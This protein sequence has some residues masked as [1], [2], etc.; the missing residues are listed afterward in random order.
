MV[1]Q[2]LLMGK[3]FLWRKGERVWGRKEE[4]GKRKEICFVVCCL[5]L[6]KYSDIVLTKQI[7][8]LFPLS[9]FL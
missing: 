1:S 3:R 5:V 8:L 9:S 2:N 6:R 4:R 7:S